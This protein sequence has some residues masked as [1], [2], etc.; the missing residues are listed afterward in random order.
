MFADNPRGIAE[1]VMARKV[2]SNGNGHTVAEDIAN[3]EREIGQLMHDIEARVGKLNA[4]ARRS[5]KDAAHD[6]SEY[7]SDTVSE[8][9]DR[10]RNG[11]HAVSDEAVRLGGDALKR[12]E[13][14]VGHR[15]LLTLAIAAGIGFLAGMAGR[16]H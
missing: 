1:D 13:E 7:V 15:P 9:A 12:I 8:A 4:L 5:A 10:V 3:I 11:A 14:E 6:A 2:Q 16:R